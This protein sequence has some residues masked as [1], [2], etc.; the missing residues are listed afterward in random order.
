MK[1]KIDQIIIRKNNHDVKFE[2]NYEQILN[3]IEINSN[4]IDLGY[5]KLHKAIKT[6]KLILSVSILT[7]V[8]AI[9]F[10]LNL[11]SS[12]NNIKND[13]KELHIF[14]Y[15]EENDIN[16]IK[17]PI[18]TEILDN[19]LVK[20]YFGLSQDN[21]VIFA[22]SVDQIEGFE[23]NI[24]SQS[25]EGDADVNI[26]Q[27]RLTETMSH[28]STINDF[29]NAYMFSLQLVLNNEIVETSNIV[30]NISDYSEYLKNMP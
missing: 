29:S 15:F 8:I 9:S 28:S 23:L 17:A 4:S 7:L 22:Y 3:R 26:D 20:I 12:L 27:T 19:H 21:K 2:N 24:I 5:K 30:I 13:S 1:N 14:Q 11:R 6:Y 18:R 10:A 25:A 16:Y